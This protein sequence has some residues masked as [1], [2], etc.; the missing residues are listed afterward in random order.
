MAV[1]DPVNDHRSD[2]FETKLYNL[3]LDAGMMIVRNVESEA[4]AMFTVLT[5]AEY[6][7]PTLALT[8]SKN[9]MSS[10]D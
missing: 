10:S 6:T 1:I 2:T 3:Q 8:Y 5:D 4:A 7:D 9:S